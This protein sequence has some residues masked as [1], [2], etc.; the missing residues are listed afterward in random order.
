MQKERFLPITY[1]EYKFNDDFPLLLMQGNQVSSQVD[2]IHF[3]N[4]IEIAFPQK[5][6][7]TWNLENK[8]CQLHPGDFCFLPPFFTHASLFP[9]QETEE[10]LC[11]YLFFNPEELLKPLYPNGLP[12]EFF[13]YRYTDF[14]KILSGDIY[15]QEKILL[16]HIIEEFSV[17]KEYYRPLVMGLIQN[18]M[19]LLC[20]RYRDNP[21]SGSGN[22]TISQL[23][24]AIS[25]MNSQFQTFTQPEILAQLCGLSTTQFLKKFQDCFG[26]TP[27]QY[28]NVIRI[29]QSCQLL[30]S[31]EETI[32]EIALKTGFSSLT[33]FNRNFLQLMGRSPTAFRSEKRA[34][35]KKDWKYAPYQAD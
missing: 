22:S 9:P 2:F 27:R 4:C 3:H 34:I 6:I 20:R 15:T 10:V 35:V 12:H 8:I 31:T 14:S 29:R 33:S 18:L 19:V 28:L 16:Q 17:Q 5:G 7:M 24:P 11:H 30:T 26:Q 32:L 21:L 23:F 13:W 1:R 25:Y